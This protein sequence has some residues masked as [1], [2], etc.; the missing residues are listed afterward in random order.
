LMNSLEG[1]YAAPTQAEL[2]SYAELKD[3][4]DAGIAKLKQIAP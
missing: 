1:A 2:N 4:A 3:L